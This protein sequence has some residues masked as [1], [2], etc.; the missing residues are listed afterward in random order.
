MPANTMMIPIANIAQ[1]TGLSWRTYS[2]T[3]CSLIPNVRYVKSSNTR[4]INTTTN[5]GAIKLINSTRLGTISTKIPKMTAMM[6]EITLLPPKT[7]VETNNAKTTAN[8]STAANSGAKYSNTPSVS[9]N[10]AII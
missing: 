5:Q 1:L 8:T 3:F 2:R 4:N 9:M 6:P 10:V 7:F